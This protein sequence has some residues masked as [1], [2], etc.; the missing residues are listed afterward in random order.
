MLS[1]IEQ[2]TIIFSCFQ[3]EI[4]FWLLELEPSQGYVR[5][6]YST[7]WSTLICIVSLLNEA[8]HI[9]FTSLS[10]ASLLYEQTGA[11]QADRQQA[12][13]LSCPEAPDR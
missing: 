4:M 9:A 13:P 5:L 3:V 2:N 12:F 11:Q 6:L 7:V 10:A 8:L 1:K